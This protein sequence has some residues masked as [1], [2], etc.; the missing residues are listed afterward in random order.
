MKG[1]PSHEIV[2]R[3]RAD[4]EQTRWNRENIIGVIKPDCMPKWAEEKLAEITNGQTQE[5][6]QIQDNNA[7][8][9]QI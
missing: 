7:D 8:M 9:Q 6:E 5:N 4:G 1:F 2:E 3:L